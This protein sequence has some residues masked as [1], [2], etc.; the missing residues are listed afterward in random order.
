MARTLT[1]ALAA[2]L[3]ALALTGI[4]HAR[5]G[6][7]ALDGGTKRQQA[8]VRGALAASSFDWSLV[9]RRIT[10]HIARGFRTEALPGEIWIDAKLLDSGMF[11]WGL[12][13]H[14]YAHQVDFFLLDDAKRA[15]LLGRLG[16]QSW[17]H[18]AGTS[19]NHADLGGERF[20]STLAWSYWMS[21]GNSL[22]PQSPSD[23]SAAMEPA[24]FRALMADTIGTSASA[25]TR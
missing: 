1:T 24:R 3:A 11:S 25:G 13:Q 16:G 17:W 6:N 9:R 8:Q 21:D 22:K 23:E 15:S 7:Y 10:I 2:L 19:A 4:A 14:E 12:V 5:G 18:V 20:A